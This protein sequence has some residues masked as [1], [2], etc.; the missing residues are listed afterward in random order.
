M[1][2]SSLEGAVDWFDFRPAMT[3]VNSSAVD[4]ACRYAYVKSFVF[5]DAK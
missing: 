3:L 1:L 4:L 5:R 2:M